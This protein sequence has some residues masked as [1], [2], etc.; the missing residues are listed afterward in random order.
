M[1][2]INFYKKVYIHVALALAWFLLAEYF[3][4]HSE[5]V[6]NTMLSMLEWYRRLLVLW[7]FMW[8]SYWTEKMM[9]NNSDKL[10][11]YSALWIY[12]LAEA[13]LFVPI[14]FI[15]ISYTQDMSLLLQATVVTLAL[16]LW[17]S[18][19]AFIT[20]KDFSFLRSALIIWV[21]IAAWLI[22]SWVLFWFTLWLLFSVLM[23]ILAWWSILYNTSNIIHKYSE[24]QYIVAALWLFSSLMLL[25]W[26]ILRIFLSRD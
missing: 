15:A 24:D 26:Y 4:L 21:F 13:L 16:F 2:K 23:V 6:V 5:V 22:I 19:V 10:T 3:M 12:V 1:G 17:I 25:F 7:W 9:I 8:V 18:A 20:K 11:Q 14:I